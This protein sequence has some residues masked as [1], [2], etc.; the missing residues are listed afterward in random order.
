MPG[1]H[2]N[3]YRLFPMANLDDEIWRADPKTRSVAKQVR[4]L[5]KK[6]LAQLLAQASTSTDPIVRGSVERYKT[7]DA[8]LRQIDVNGSG[9]IEEEERERD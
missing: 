3:R 7:L 9:K 6:A 8:F 1:W 2:R 5:R 4:T